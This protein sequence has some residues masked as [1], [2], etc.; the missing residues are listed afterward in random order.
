MGPFDWEA[1]GNIAH[2][3]FP[4]VTESRVWKTELSD[5]VAHYEARGLNPPFHLWRPELSLETIR[6]LTMKYR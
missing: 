6:F 4:Y 5:I 1:S 2:R 3:E